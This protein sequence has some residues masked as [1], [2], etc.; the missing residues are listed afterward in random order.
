MGY[1]VTCEIC[2]VEEK[3]YLTCGCYKKRNSEISQLKIGCKILHTVIDDDFI[4]EKLETPN[5]EIIFIQTSLGNKGG[6][7]KIIDENC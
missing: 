4:F 6:V 3:Y 5:G 7:S 1:Y 2:G